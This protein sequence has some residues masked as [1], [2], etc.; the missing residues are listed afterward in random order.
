MATLSLTGKRWVLEEQP[1][2]AAE[3]AA[4]LL[5]SLARKRAIDMGKPSSLPLEDASS[6][7]PDLE[8]AIARIRTAV[9]RKERVGIFGDYDCDGITG[10]AQLLRA[11]RRRQLPVYARLPHR[12]REGYG[13]KEEIIREFA[14]EKITLLITIDTGITAL[15][16]LALARTLGM[17]IIVIDHHHL[18]EAL[19][20]ASALIHPGLA[21]NPSERQRASGSWPSAAGLAYGLIAAWERTEGSDVWDGRDTDLSLAAVGT[22][23]DLVELKGENRELVAA[24]VR[25]LR[26][27]PENEPL[28]LLARQAGLAGEITSRDI[29]FRIAPRLNAAG[30][31]AD[32]D[33]ALQALL[34]DMQ[35]ILALER[36]NQERQRAVQEILTELE[37]STFAHSDAPFLSLLSP[38]Y[39]AGVLGLIAGRLTEAHGK[40]SL[41]AQMQGTMGVA[42]LRSIPG[43]HVTEALAAC[44]D[45]LT[46]FGGHAMAAGCTFPVEAFDELASRLTERAAASLTPEQL[47]PTLSIDAM[48]DPSHVTLPLCETLSN[49]EPFGQGNPEPRF[50]LPHV[51]FTT[52]KRI[53]KEF[54]HV[55]GTI[56]DLKCV[57]F[58]LGSYYEK[59]PDTVDIACRI[60]IDTW[61]GN[62]RPQIIIEDVREAIPVS[63]VGER[64]TPESITY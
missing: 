48:L 51:R 33:V 11:F 45:L 56:G 61:N 36:L 64:S 32:P 62:R 12:Q 35:S 34:G 1:S 54:A 41:V 5:A 46:S 60:G 10:V 16:E 8:K 59:M 18:P 28:T 15:K 37:R 53:G 6:V 49:L 4:G 25:A 58:R 14:G 30:R 27:L 42:S 31:M 63:V 29:A 40:P 38:D 43:F 52:L 20:Q 57:G 47:R 7:P 13:L 21:M 26:T 55:Q 44:G 24:G 22:V 19:P 39:P 17:D 50:L 2:A 23:A 3:G 9:A